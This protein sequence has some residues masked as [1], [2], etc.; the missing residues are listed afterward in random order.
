MACS[1]LWLTCRRQA[2]NDRVIGAE[3]LN[4]I[5]RFGLKRL[6]GVNVKGHALECLTGISPAKSIRGLFPDRRRRRSFREKLNKARS[7]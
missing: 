5:E 3:P 7:R 4:V 6:P 1:D 2:D